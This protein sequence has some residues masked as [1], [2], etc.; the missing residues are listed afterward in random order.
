[1]QWHDLYKTKKYF[2]EYNKMCNGNET[3]RYVSDKNEI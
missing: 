3:G 1:M 2:Y